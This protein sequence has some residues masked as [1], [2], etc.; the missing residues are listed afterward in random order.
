MKKNYPQHIGGTPIN[1]EMNALITEEK[2][3]TSDQT[4]FNQN[5]Y[6][7]VNGIVEKHPRPQ[8]AWR[9][10]RKEAQRNISVAFNYIPS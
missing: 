3:N 8:I 2:Q 5:I 10:N 4:L 1:D 6:K 7:I 9:R